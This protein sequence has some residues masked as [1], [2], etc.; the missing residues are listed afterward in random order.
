MDLDN[1]EFY[2][3]RVNNMLAQKKSILFERQKAFPD[4]ESFANIINTDM[5]IETF[6]TLLPTQEECL[7]SVDILKSLYD[8]KDYIGPSLG[9][10]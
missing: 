3:H 9:N 5:A 8:G 6:K 7:Q 10:L 1:H 2:R 4:E